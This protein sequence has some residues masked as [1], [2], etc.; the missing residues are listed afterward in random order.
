MRA[1]VD[2]HA[3][4]GGASRAAAICT[5]RCAVSPSPGTSICRLLLVDDAG[6]REPRSQCDG[7]SSASISSPQSGMSATNC[8]ANGTCASS[9]L[10]RAAVDDGLLA[11][12]GARDELDGIESDPDQQIALVDHRLLDRGVGEDAG[13]PRMIVGHDSLGLVG[14][15]R[16][17]VP[18]GAERSNGGGIRRTA[19]AKADEQQRLARGGQKRL[20]PRPRICRRHSLLE[21][22]AGRIEQRRHRVRHAARAIHVH[23]SGPAD[24]RRMQRLLDRLQRRIW[25]QSRRA[26]A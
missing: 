6:A 22:D 11:L 4:G 12:P 13:E 7:A 3:S 18:R 1:G 16:R 5:T 24:S 21:F 10:P 26:H 15:H 2:G 8:T 19:S 25:R 20:E 23:R 14:D 17:D 9:T